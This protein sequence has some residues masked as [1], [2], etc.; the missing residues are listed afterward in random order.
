MGFK[1]STDFQQKILLENYE[2]PFGRDATLNAVLPW[3]VARLSVCLAVCDV[4][5]L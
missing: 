1:F 2:F 5:V 3:Q 4:E